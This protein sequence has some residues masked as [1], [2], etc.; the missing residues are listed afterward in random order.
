MSTRSSEMF[1]VSAVI[2]TKNEES[3][4]SRC[5]SSIMWCDEII[6]VDDYSEDSTIN[7]AK[8][9]N[10]KVYKR[11][12]NGDFSS[13]RNFG[14]EKTKNDWILFVDADEEISKELKDSILSEINNPKF[15][16]YGMKRTNI[17]LGKT[18]L[19]NEGSNNS[20]VRLVNKK[21]GVWKRKV[22]ETW[23][24]NKKIGQLS[25][26]IFHY[27]SRDLSSFI[28]KINNYSDIHASEIMHE[29]K[30]VGLHKILIYPI[31]K[32]VINYVFQKGYKDSEHGFVM[33]ILMSFHSFLSWSKLYLEK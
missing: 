17:F 20:L 4:L 9:Y 27:T 23:R 19:S 7:I 30:L 5:L 33:S 29:G 6:V 14:A 16:A 25:G 3:N 31:G 22:H 1:K 8:K 21:Y 26:A 32:F 10:A 28:H 15:Y 2:I 18:M 24:T 13:Q 12:L 11:S